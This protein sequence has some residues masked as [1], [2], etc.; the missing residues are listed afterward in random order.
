MNVDWNIQKRS[1]NCVFCEKEFGD[2]E[3]V[4]CFLNLHDAEALR[5]DYC[6]SCWGETKLERAGIEHFSYW[7]THYRK[8]IPIT[9]EDPVKRDQIELMLKKYITSESPAHKNLCYILAAMLERKR[10]ISQKDTTTDP[11]GQKILVYEQNKTGE[12]FLI[13]DP[14]LKLNEIGG[15]Q[16]QVKALLDEEAQQAAAATQPEAENEIS[17][18]SEED[19]ESVPEQTSEEEIAE[20][21]S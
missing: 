3:T 18:Q 20:Q 10:I 8:V 16:Q 5:K 19:E 14:Q 4:H 9:K 6:L 12:T 21:T 15:V 7:Q 1:S 2:Q 13:L 17:E 11:S